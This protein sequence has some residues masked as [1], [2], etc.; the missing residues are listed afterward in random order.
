MVL[1]VFDAHRVHR[2]SARCAVRN[3]LPYTQPPALDVIRA[4]LARARDS[5][6]SY[7]L[8][9]DVDRSLYVLWAGLCGILEAI[10]FWWLS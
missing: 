4:I 8:I 7:T 6:D 2:R 3:A 10:I 1:G 5:P 9:R